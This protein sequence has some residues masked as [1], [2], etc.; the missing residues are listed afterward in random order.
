LL[1]TDDEATLT[2]GDLETTGA[3]LIRRW[4]ND[5]TMIETVRGAAKPKG[6]A[7]P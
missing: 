5:G 4:A 2:A 7:S 6:E 3:V 1:P